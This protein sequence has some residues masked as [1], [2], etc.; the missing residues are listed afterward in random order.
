M[1]G[2]S[3]IDRNPRS[4]GAE[5]WAG[6]WNTEGGGEESDWRVSR[7]RQMYPAVELGG[8]LDGTIGCQVPSG[9]SLG[10][11][12]CWGMAWS[13]SPLL[14]VLPR[15]ADLGSGMEGRVRSLVERVRACFLTPSPASRRP[16]LKRWKE[17]PQ[18][19][20]GM[21]PDMSVDCVVHGRTGVH[22]GA[23]LRAR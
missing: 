14:S 1:T 5:W 8:W 4:G 13:G 11:G 10:P 6:G 18:Q 21:Q 2:E 12:C 15:A 16:L 7:G 19:D 17:A 20:D 3:I 23:S 9:G 22:F